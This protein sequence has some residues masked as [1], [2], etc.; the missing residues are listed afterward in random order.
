[1]LV[2]DEQL[3]PYHTI[4][5]FFFFCRRTR[6]HGD[7]RGQDDF[8]DVALTA[9]ANSYSNLARPIPKTWVFKH[10]AMHVYESH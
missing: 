2:R 10:A 7:F 1:M 4:E 5:G 9:R 8:V 6:G 3:Q